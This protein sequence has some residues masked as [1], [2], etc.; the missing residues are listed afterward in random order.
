MA[1]LRTPY[2]QLTKQESENIQAMNI[3]NRYKAT[4]K[5]AYASKDDYLAVKKVATA[6]AETVSFFKTN[7]IEYW[8][9][10]QA[11]LKEYNDFELNRKYKNKF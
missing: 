2:S 9:K 6:S 5:S 11:L 8:E 7:A 1:I 4:L 10:S 3:Y